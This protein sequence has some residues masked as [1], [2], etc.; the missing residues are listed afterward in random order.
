MRVHFAFETT[1]ELRR[2]LLEQFRQ[3]QLARMDAIE[4]K[5]QG[6]VAIAQS[7]ELMARIDIQL[8]ASQGN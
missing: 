5:T 1:R 8:A 3:A 2:H 6:A 7:R 4:A